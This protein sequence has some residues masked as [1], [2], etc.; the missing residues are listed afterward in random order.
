MQGER[1]CGAVALMIQAF[2]LR[3]TCDSKCL[4]LCDS[5]RLPVA[6]LDPQY[7]GVGTTSR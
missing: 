2:G 1:V 3:G 5:D 7:A 6:L 4:L